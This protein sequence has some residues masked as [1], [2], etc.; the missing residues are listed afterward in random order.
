MRALLLTSAALLLWG[1]AARAQEAVS[2]RAADGV[3]VHAA[4]YPATGHRGIVVAFHMAG[5]NKAEY[6]P[7]A[8][9]LVR[10]GF[11]VIAV[12]QRSGGPL[13]GQRN[14][15]A[16]GVGGAPGFTGA[17]PDMEAALAYAEGL[18]PGRPVLVIGSSYSASLA[19]VLAAR[20]PEVAGVAAFSP[21]EYFSTLS[22]RAAA[23]KLASPLF[24]TSA[25]DGAEV[26][27]ARALLDASPAR[28]KRQFIPRNGVHGT[29]TLRPDEDPRGAEANWAALEAFLAIAIPPPP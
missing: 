6:A 5:S 16:L 24:V 11:T 28:L 3:L 12:D 1:A 13:W 26:A 22:V 29:S 14:E 25:P 8:P 21:G 20:H 2:F 17:L 7:I 27:A 10:D 15:T 18:E 19:F 9:R 23:A 4:R